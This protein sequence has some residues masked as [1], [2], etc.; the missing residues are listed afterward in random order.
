MAAARS[1][2]A[3][4]R[5]SRP[6]SRLSRDRPSWLSA[7]AFSQL[8]QPTQSFSSISSTSVASPMPFGD[9]EAGD[10]ASTCRRRRRSR[11]CAPR[12][13][14]SICWRAAISRLHPRRAARACRRAAC[15]RR[16][17]QL[18]HLGLD[19]GAHR[20]RAPAAVDQRHLADIGAGGQVAQEDRLAADRSSRR[21][22]ALAD[23]ED[24]IALVA[25][26][27][28][29]LAGADLLDLGGL[30]QRPS[31][32]RRSAGAERSAAACRSV[33]MRVI[34]RL[35]APNWSPSASARRCAGSRSRSQPA[36][37]A[38]WRPRLRPEIR[39]TSPKIEPCAIGAVIARSFGSTSTSD[40]PSA[41]ANSEAPGSLRSNTIS[42]GAVGPRLRNRA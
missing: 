17:R 14:W 19:R 18:D 22:R 13:S 20:R 2:R 28:D 34:S 10:R 25:L 27:D 29:R 35:R 24:V 3:G 16:R 11:P 1:A 26:V 37:R 40:E 15:G 38:R 31:G 30:E 4:G 6:A 5:R 21:H 41:I 7:Q 32:R 33:T 39:P 8:S 23:D 9:Q 12:R 42:P 36:R